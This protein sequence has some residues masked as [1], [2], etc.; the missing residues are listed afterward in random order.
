MTF[1]DLD[2]L[3]GDAAQ[4]APDTYLKKLPMGSGTIQ[5]WDSMEKYWHRIIYNYLRCDPEYFKFILT[6]PPMNPPEN[7]EKVAEIFFETF[8]V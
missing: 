4:A 6:E 5:D 3:I 7:R 2:F 8:G 1:E